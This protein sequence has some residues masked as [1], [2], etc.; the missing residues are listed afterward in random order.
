MTARDHG[1]QPERT[2]LSWRRTVMASALVAALL[3]R[4]GLAHD[5]PVAI[6]AA[7]CL[8]MPLVAARVRSAGGRPRTALLI[9]AIGVLGAGLLTIAQVLLQR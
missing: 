2:G 4:D 6:A 9:A 8:I 5:A 1:L 3:M 7:A